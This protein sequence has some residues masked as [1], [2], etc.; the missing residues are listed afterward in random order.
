MP[1]N[2]VL[3]ERH[4]DTAFAAPDGIQKLREL[5]LT[6]AIQGKLV[7]QDPNDQ[8][9]SELL[10]A[11][12]VEKLRLLKEGK[13]KQIKPLPRIK[14]EEMTYQLPIGWKWVRLGDLGE[15]QTGTT[16]PTKDA[17]NLGDFIPF[18]GPGD[19]KNHAIDYFGEGLSEVGLA[20]GRLI[21]KNSVL[22]VCIGGS[23]GK[24]AINDRD[25]TCNQQINAITPYKREF[26]KYMFFALGEKFFQKMVIAQSSGS[27][28]PIINKQKWSSI[29]IPLPPIAEQR[30]I[31]A[32][33]DQ[34]MARCDELEKL[35]GDRLNINDVKVYAIIDITDVDQNYIKETEQANGIK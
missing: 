23:I 5:I 6:L 13:I 33:I 10:K 30:R 24:H 17:E 7:P 18:V 2:T 25:I 31:V 28:T 3:L 4:F 11:I 16:P 19:I 8:P 20:R 9:A 12:E 26:V 21:K 14:P 34:L 29:P 15:A 1:D 27:A 22:M 35:R 32:K